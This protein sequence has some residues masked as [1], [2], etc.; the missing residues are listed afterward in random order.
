[1]KQVRVGIVGAGFVSEIHA[2][3]YR[4]IGRAN[5]ELVAV[6]SRSHDSAASFAARFDIPDVVGVDELLR[7]EDVDVID[8]CVPN[9]S[10]EALTIAAARAGKH[11]ICE[12]P[13][14]GCFEMTDTD[15]KPLTKKQMLSAALASAD[16]MMDACTS[17]GVQLMYAENWAYMPAIDRAAELVA[18]S[19]GVILEM[20][21]EESH[22]GSHSAAARR[23][24]DSGGGSMMMLGAH[25]LGALLRL[26]REEGL[27]RNGRPIRARS[28]LAQTADLT[29]V[30]A[31]DA[32]DSYVLKAWEDV[33]NWCLSVITFE[34][35]A[36]AVVT[37]SYNCVGG[38]RDTL[39]IYAT[40]MRVH[41]NLSNNSMLQAYA[42]SED[43]FR[44][45]ELAEKLE[46]NA[47]WS[48]PAVGDDMLQGY[49]RELGDFVDAVSSG[50]PALSDGSLGRDVLELIYGSYASAESGTAFPL[51]GDRPG[52]T[53]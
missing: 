28:V 35:G 52:V 42:P 32:A 12:K 51:G 45:V 10:H 20:R 30:A 22:H 7:R 4:S 18:A 16:R 1:M 19:G 38:M 37:A 9:A 49:S 6:S 43:V 23:W 33:E 36:R 31:F 2:R 11:V 25:P 3:A 5:V 39:E 26:K 14:T 27:R 47:G 17:N 48:Y 13:L 8:V 34:D 50:R 40:N 24:K 46:T 15:G 41:C 44:G 21:A 29:D 53:R